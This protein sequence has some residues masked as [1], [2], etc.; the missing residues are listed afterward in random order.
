MRRGGDDR[1]NSLIGDAAGVP[2]M[3]YSLWS[4]IFRMTE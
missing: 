4:E 2:A 3:D 1:S